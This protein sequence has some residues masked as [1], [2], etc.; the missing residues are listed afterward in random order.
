MISTLPAKLGRLGAI[1]TAGMSLAVMGLAPHVALGQDQVPAAA[2]AV[3]FEEAMACSALFAILSASA[4]YETEEA[5]LL[6]LS[7]QWLAAASKRAE[8]VGAIANETELRL[9]VDELLGLMGD[10]EDDAQR[11]SFLLFSIDQCEAKYLLIP[12]EFDI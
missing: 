2:E 8:A 9:W 7:A 11:E 6:D 4:E 3:S 10:Q 12:D 1:I 5:Q